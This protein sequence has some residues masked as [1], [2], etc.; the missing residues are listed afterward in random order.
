MNENWSVVI[1]QVATE[2]YGEFDVVLELTL[3]NFYDD[4]HYI[5]VH[6]LFRNS[7]LGMKSKLKILLSISV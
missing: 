6:Y 5:V 3:S 4:I 1:S 7:L 2:F